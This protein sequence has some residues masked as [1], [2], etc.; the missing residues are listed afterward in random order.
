MDGPRESTS[1]QPSLPPT[2]EGEDVPS[3][4]VNGGREGYVPWI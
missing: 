4:D 3:E 2:A 1:K